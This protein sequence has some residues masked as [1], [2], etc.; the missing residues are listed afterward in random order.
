MYLAFL[1]LASAFVCACRPQDSGPQEKE[2][3]LPPLPT[4]AYFIDPHA[5]GLVIKADRQNPIKLRLARHRPGH[6]DLWIDGVNRGAGSFSPKASPPTPGAP[7]AP[8]GPFSLQRDELVIR[9]Q[10]AMVAGRHRL[11]LFTPA[12]QSRGWSTPIVLQVRHSA[13]RK[14]DLR[15]GPAWAPAVQRVLHPSNGT[16]NHGR[17]ALIEAGGDA[18]DP[19]A[20]T[21]WEAAGSIDPKR[22]TFRGELPRKGPRLEFAE[23]I[24]LD[25]RPELKRYRIY[26]SYPNAPHGVWQLE[27]DRAGN[28][29]PWEFIEVPDR[30]SQSQRVTDLRVDARGLWVQVEEHGYIDKDYFSYSNLLHLDDPEG[31]ESPNSPES[32]DNPEG[33]EDTK[34]TKARAQSPSKGPK[35]PKWRNPFGKK[36]IQRRFLG[37]EWSQLTAEPHGVEFVARDIAATRARLP[38]PNA[39]QPSGL[40]DP[41]TQLAKVCSYQGPLGE[42]LWAGVDDQGA[43]AAGHSHQSSDRGQKIKIPSLLKQSQKKPELRKNFFAPRCS[44]VEGRFLSLFIHRPSGTLHSLSFDGIDFLYQSHSPD[45]RCQD[46]VL[47]GPAPTSPATNPATKANPGKTR[48]GWCLQERQLIPLE[49]QLR[50]ASP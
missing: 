31:P 33:L 36:R 12:Y 10:G 27:W 7:G 34:D 8:G 2:L 32:P 44:V 13:P 3:E 47:E 29:R 43:I 17:L 6:S 20:V 9:L 19:G 22:P 41:A 5:G 11:Q 50:P 23:A 26:A 28:M 35:P 24:A 46:L 40:Q 18:Q 1:G 49:V 45:L 38:A 4:A 16:L 39:P 30:S 48:V 42:T 25:A 21:F 15:A 37:V 14:V